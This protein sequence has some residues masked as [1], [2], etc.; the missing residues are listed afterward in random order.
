MSKIIL[1]SGPVIVENSK[2]LLDKSGEDDFWKFCGGRVKGNEALPET[3]KRRAKEELG[4]DVKIINNEPFVR[5]FKKETEKGEIEVILFHF[6]A[7]RNGEVVAGKDVRE[8]QWLDLNDLPDDLGENILPA[9][10]FF[11]LI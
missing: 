2:V 5:Y 8:W 1:V 4:I 10:K 11:S 3:A 6:L 7:K 9:L